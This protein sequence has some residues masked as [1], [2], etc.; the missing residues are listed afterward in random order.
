ME[1]RS[2]KPGT[3]AQRLTAGKLVGSAVVGRWQNNT[4]LPPH[5]PQVIPVLLTVERIADEVLA[6]CGV[7]VGKPGVT[8]R[9]K[10]PLVDSNICGRSAAVHMSGRKL[11]LG[12]ARRSAP[13]RRQTQKPRTEVRGSSF[14]L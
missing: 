14:G 10:A 5:D 12:R 11:R 2:E 4:A 3:C 1:R 8:Q 13:L 6:A 9:P 7:G